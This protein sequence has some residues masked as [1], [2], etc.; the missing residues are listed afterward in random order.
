MSLGSRLTNLRKSKQLSQEEVA[1]RLNV[2]RQTVSKWET[3]QSEPD[4]NK[5]IP[6]CE[7]Y[8]ISP[9]E[10][11]TGTKK[12]QE[13]AE[14]QTD[15]E[16]NKK[17][18]LGLIIGIFGYFIAIAWIIIS[19]VTFMIDPI[20]ST[21]VFLLMIGISTCI[22]IYTSIIYKSKK[23]N[24]EKEED[25]IYK[26]VDNI[27]AIIFL[28]IY[29]YISFKTMAWHITWIIWIICGLVSKI[30]KLIISLRGENEK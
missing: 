30:V 19:V 28:I 16:N 27:I 1:F 29:L 26:K 3:D 13:R 20:I 5:I 10:L 15:E 8:E 21:A 2:T 17:R 25:S 4:F 14:K 9:D 11:L 6:L 7:L 23:I 22:I 24:E 12:T 18:T